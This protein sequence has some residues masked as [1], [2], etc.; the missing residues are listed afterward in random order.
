MLQLYTDRALTILHTQELEV[1]EEEEEDDEV[2]SGSDGSDVES[3]EIVHQGTQG[4][5]DVNA[6]GP[7]S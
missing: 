3:L 2:E 1:E 7:F 5:D 6:S 4:A